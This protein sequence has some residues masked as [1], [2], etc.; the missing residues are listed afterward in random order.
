MMYNLLIK[1]F[2]FLFPPE[3]AHHLA[4]RLFRIALAVPFISTFLKQSLKSR[5]A[6]TQVMGLS[7]PNKVGL[8]AGFDKDGKHIKSFPKLGFGFYEIGT[9]TPKPQAGNPKPRLFR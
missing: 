7:F 3:K 6:S 1:P 4:L 2:L 9:V 5:T 8:A